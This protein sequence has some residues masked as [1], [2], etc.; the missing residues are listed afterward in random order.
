MEKRIFY[1]Y[2]AQT[3]SG[4]FFSGMIGV[5]D[6]NVNPQAEAWNKAKEVCEQN[7]GTGKFAFR[8]FKRVD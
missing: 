1:F 4:E 5:L 6:T 7:L 3:S 8:D 2:A